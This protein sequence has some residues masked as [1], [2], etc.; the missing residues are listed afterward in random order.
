MEILEG[1]LFGRLTGAALGSYANAGQ[2]NNLKLR[3]NG[4]GYNIP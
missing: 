1:I 2:V 4:I 3:G